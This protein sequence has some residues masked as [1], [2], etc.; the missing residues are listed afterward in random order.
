MNQVKIEYFEKGQKSFIWEVPSNWTEAIENKDW[1]SLDNL[2]F[3]ALGETGQLREV[4]AKLCPVQ[5]IEHL[6]SLREAPDEDGIWHDD[7]SRDLAFSLALS[8]KPFKGDGLS[9]RIKGENQSA[10][11]LGYRPYGTLT[12]FL[13][14]S[15][16]FEH[17]TNQVLSGSRLV[18]AGWVN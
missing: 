14:G 16:G 8:L 15:N 3:E 7:G 17:R 9:L 4:L 5:K 6:I 2:A 18:L 11:S 12:C 1:N 10:Y 13:T